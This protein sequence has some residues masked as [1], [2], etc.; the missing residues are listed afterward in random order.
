MSPVGVSLITLLL[1]V[2][3]MYGIIVGV[4]VWLSEY[5]RLSVAEKTKLFVSHFSK[6]MSLVTEVPLMLIAVIEALLFVDAAM[7]AFAVDINFINLLL[8]P[9]RAI[10]VLLVSST[11][12]SIITV[13]TAVAVKVQ[14]LV[15]RLVSPENVSH[16]T[17]PILVLSFGI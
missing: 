8:S 3:F 14:E 2:N 11:V 1:L 15:P 7:V 6:I 12:A 16:V 10:V 9:V 17:V 5:P 13:L 4:S